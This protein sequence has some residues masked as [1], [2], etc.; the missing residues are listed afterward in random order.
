MALDKNKAIAVLMP[1]QEEIEF[2]TIGLAECGFRR[3][4]SFRTAEEAY[5][6]VTRQQ[7]D[8]FITRM[9]MPKMSGIVFIQKIRETGNYG[10]ETHLF[11]CDSIQSSLLALLF[12]LDLPYV[13]TKPFH[14]NILLQKF[15]HLISCEATLSPEEEIF[16]EARSAY[17]N[18]I[19]DLALDAVD[20][21]LKLKPTLEKAL[22]LKGDILLKQNEIGKAEAVFQS[23]LKVNG[24]SLTAGHKLAQVALLQN[25]PIDA[26]ALLN[27]MADLNPYHIKILE[28]A[29]VSCLRADLIEDA[30][31]HMGKLSSIDPKNRVAATVTAEVSIKHGNYDSIVTTLGK[32]MNEK[33]IIQ[34]LNNAGIKLSKDNDVVG[35]LKMYKAA[36]QQLEGK[37][38]LL[39]AIYY[40]MGIAYKRLD[41]KM[42]SAVCYRKALKLNPTFDKAKQALTELDS[43]V[44]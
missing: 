28:N 34:F 31:R 40:N 12:E 39:Y 9:E 6:L 5:E 38:P 21:V 14:K 8:A 32:S 42:N 13:M 43:K 11:T 36:A 2:F 1:T 22:V 41:D 17:F 19:P 15:K 37:T 23:V 26:A 20:R 30:E 3:V 44:A 33:E 29:G 16:R 25:R 10:S 35:A 18:N 27:K 7:F 4:V 24:R